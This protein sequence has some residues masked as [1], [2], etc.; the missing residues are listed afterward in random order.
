MLMVDLP[1]SFGVMGVPPLSAQVLNLLMSSCV[2]R[3]K[4]FSRRLRIMFVSTRN[5]DQS[6]LLTLMLV[7]KAGPLEIVRL[8]SEIT[9]II[10]TSLYKRLWASG[11]VFVSPAG[12]SWS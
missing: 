4:E 12:G 10:S 8:V 6:L 7:P 5:C 9:M 1:E 3:T 11:E 2:V